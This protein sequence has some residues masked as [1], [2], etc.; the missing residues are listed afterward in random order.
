MRND[1]I[2]K[3]TDSSRELTAREKLKFADTQTCISLDSLIDE[4]G[5]KFVFNPA[6]YVCLDIH[7]EHSENVD[8]TKF[9]VIS[10]DGNMYATGSQSFK[11]SFIQIME[12]MED[13]GEKDFEIECYKVKSKNYNGSFIKCSIV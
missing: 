9:I 12:V 13:S 3:I 7:N 10:S 5:G 2:V 1:Y 8:Y 4:N 11:D 6:D